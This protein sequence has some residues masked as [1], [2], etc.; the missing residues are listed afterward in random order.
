MFDL[1][2]ETQDI[3]LHFIEEN[4][5][6]EYICKDLDEE[7]SKATK[8]AVTEAYNSATAL[9]DKVYELKDKIKVDIQEA[10]MVNLK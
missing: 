2:K 10:N 9:E 7:F 3:I 5:D 6:I 4:A 1:L 8:V